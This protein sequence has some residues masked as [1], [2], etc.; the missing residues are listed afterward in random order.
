MNNYTSGSTFNYTPSAANGNNMKNNENVNT[1]LP[2]TANI[3]QPTF[4]SKYT[5][6]LY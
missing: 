2:P 6:E 5:K 1:N 4:V 3:S